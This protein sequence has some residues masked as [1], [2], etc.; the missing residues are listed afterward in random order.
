M[1]PALYRLSVFKARSMFSQR[2]STSAKGLAATF[3][4]QK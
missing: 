3:R 2:S 1:I 4:I